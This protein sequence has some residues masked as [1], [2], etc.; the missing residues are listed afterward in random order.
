MLAPLSALP[1]G[2]RKCRPGQRNRTVVQ[3]SHS[4]WTPRKLLHFGGLAVD[5]LS[6]ALTLAPLTLSWAMEKTITMIAYGANARTIDPGQDQQRRHGD[7]RGVDVA[8]LVAD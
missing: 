4:Y 8:E 7:Q 1:F 3:F 6:S 2:G 5:G